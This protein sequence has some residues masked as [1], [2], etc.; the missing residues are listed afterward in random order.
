MNW[1][2]LAMAAALVVTVPAWA[3]SMTASQ[4]NAVRSARQ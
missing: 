1:L 4:N 3:E 2:K